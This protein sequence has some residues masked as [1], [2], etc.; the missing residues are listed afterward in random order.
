MGSEEVVRGIERP[1]SPSRRFGQSFH[2]WLPSELRSSSIGELDSA[3]KPV[4]LYASDSALAKYAAK[5]LGYRRRKGLDLIILGKSRAVF[6]EAKFIS[7]S[8]GT[9]DKS[10]REATEFVRKYSSSR[11]RAIA[12]IDGVV[13]APSIIERKNSLYARE[14]AGLKNDHV[15]LSSL[16]LREFVKREL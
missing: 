9:Q 6:G 13:W 12:V 2:K 3:K 15:V 4:S 10:F 7:T 11:A 1:M 8:G 5:N 14:I 16:L